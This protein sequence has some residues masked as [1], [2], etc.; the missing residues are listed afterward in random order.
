MKRTAIVAGLLAA[1]ACTP[2]PAITSGPFTPATVTVVG[3]SIS[4]GTWGNTDPGVHWWEHVTAHYDAEVT[5]SAQPGW[6]SLD[7]IAAPPTHRAD[8]V[9]IALGSND[10]IIRHDP[11]HY[12]ELL[13]H[14]ASWGDA[15]VIAA[16]W[17]RTGWALATAPSDLIPLFAYRLNAYK[18]A[19]DS[20]C[21]F[22]DWGQFST[23]APNMTADG[24]HPTPY[25]NEQLANSV[26]AV[27][28]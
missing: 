26:W 11:V 20:G 7:A 15:C 14:M 6:T 10:Q 3:D 5:V 28:K 12:R 16:P 17:E 13:M 9:L 19:I 25:G 21:A 1:S 8:L 4:A 2:L 23:A 24:L 22:V 27:I 18:A